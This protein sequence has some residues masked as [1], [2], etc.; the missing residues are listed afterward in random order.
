MSEAANRDI[1]INEGA[2]WSMRLTWKADGDPVDLTGF[3]AKMQLRKTYGTPVLVELT[4]G[5][6]IVLGGADGTIDLTIP[7]PLTLDLPPTSLYDLVMTSAGGQV[8]RLVQGSVRKV[9]GVTL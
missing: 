4:D 5:D 6:G 1:S 2:D 9:P 7:A 8:T 3:T